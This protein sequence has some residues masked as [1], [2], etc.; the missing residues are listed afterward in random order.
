[1]AT[2][3]RTTHVLIDDEF[4]QWIFEVMS[5]MCWVADDSEKSKL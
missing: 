5:F 2:K 4:Y 1:M 3:S